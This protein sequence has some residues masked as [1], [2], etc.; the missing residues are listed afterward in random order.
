MGTAKVQGEL[1]GSA[2]HDWATIL[3]KAHRPLMDAM[4]TATKVGAGTR[5]L[6]AGCGSGGASALAAARG[7]QIWGLDVSENMIAYAGQ[8]LPQGDFRVGD[9]QLLP[10][11][12]DAFDVVCAANSVQYSADR[13][14]TLRG[15]ERVCRSG[16]YI[17]AGLF[18]SPDKVT[19]ASVLKAIGSVMPDGPKG[20]GPF[21]LSMPGVLEGLF[22]EAGLNVVES[23]EVD[24]PFTYPNFETFWRGHLSAG[25]IQGMLRVV[26][27]ERLRT[28]VREA[29]EPFTQADGRIL[30]APNF[31]KYVVAVP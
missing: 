7:A 27:R 16:G 1:W 29:V 8:R 2:P 10:Y 17:V 9:I 4:L 24:C 21:E 3:E 20:G 15:F 25:P 30:I 12:E 23:S 19:Y 14:A 13:V 11:E 28:A 6:D 18:G 31:F 22:Q 26:G 5:F